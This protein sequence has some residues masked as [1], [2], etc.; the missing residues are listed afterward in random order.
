MSMEQF[1][2]GPWAYPRNAQP[3]KWFICDAD[4][5]GVALMIT[6]GMPTERLDANSRLLAASWE[7]MELL[8]E[9]GTQYGEDTPTW[10]RADALIARVEGREVHE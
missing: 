4:G 7:M 10:R 1:S 3:D 2:P 8:H 9:I 6:F 5:R